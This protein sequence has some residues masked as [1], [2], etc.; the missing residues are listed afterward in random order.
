D[1]GAFDKGHLVRRD[2]VCWG[3]TYE[4]I[5]MANGDTFHVTNCSP[6]TKVFNQGQEGE[7]N[8]GDLEDFIAKVTKQ[9]SEKVCIFAGPI[10]G[11]D[12]RWFRGKDDQGSA[13]IQIPNRYWKIV[14]SKSTT[15]PKAYGFVLKQDVRS[16]TEK[17]FFVTDEWMAALTSIKDIAADLR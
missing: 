17:E 11:Q 3:K 10:F 13:R 8:W 16:V 4:E 5:Q 9:E 6:Q 2:D 12:D 7:E 15:G 14:V 1:R